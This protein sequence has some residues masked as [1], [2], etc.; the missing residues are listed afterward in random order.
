MYVTVPV[1]S[2]YHL[3]SL[4]E[5][6]LFSLQQDQNPVLDVDLHFTTG[7]YSSNALFQ[8]FHLNAKT[9]KIQRVFRSRAHLLSHELHI[10]RTPGEGV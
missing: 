2:V 10:D 5:S 7:L 3:K 4:A 1:L 8:P 6:H 9:C